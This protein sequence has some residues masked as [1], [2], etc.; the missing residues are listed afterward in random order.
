M[1]P[2]RT[3]TVW[4]ATLGVPFWSLS[5]PVGAVLPAVGV[6]WLRTRARLIRS[7]AIVAD[8]LPE[9]R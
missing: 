8:L 2:L 9:A 7:G 4:T 1:S 6:Y 3:G 5:V